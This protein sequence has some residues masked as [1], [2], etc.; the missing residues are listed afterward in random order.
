MDLKKSI[1]CYFIFFVISSNIVTG[2]VKK[3]ASVA[4]SFFKNGLVARESYIGSDQIL[5]SIKTYHLVGGL[6]EKFYFNKKKQLEGLCQKFSTEG[7]LMTSWLYQKGVLSY[8]K[9]YFKE[10]NLKN[11]EITES[12]YANIE[13]CNLLLKTNPNNFSLIYSRAV[14]QDYLSNNIVSELDF[15]FLKDL[16]ENAKVNTKE[17]ETEKIN[18]LNRKLA[19][20]Y[21]RL[22]SI[23]SRYENDYLSIEYKLKAVQAE[24]TSNIY[25]YNLGAA[26]AIQVEDYRLALYFLEEVTRTKPNHNFANWV[27][28]HIYLEMEQYQKA[29]DCVNIAFKS[30]RGLYENGYGNVEDDLRTIRGLVYHKLGKTELGIG[31]LNKALEINNKNAVANKNLGIVY[32]DL[33]ENQ[34]ACAYFQKS[35]ALG[36]EKKYYNKSLESHIKKNCTLENPILDNSVTINQNND[37][38][39]EVLASQKSTTTSEIS[40]KDLPYIAPNPAIDFVEVYNY[41]PVD[42]NFNIFDTAGKQILVGISNH[43]TIQVS[44]LPTGFY[45]LTIEKDGKTEKFKLIKK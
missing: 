42:F 5:D 32:S 40:V 30:E 10:F 14:S 24:P 15:L 4:K 8:R 43:K 25:L 35:R 17:S 23:Y 38:E 9:D 29:L 11:K 44:G 28:S 22:S 31:D 33:G 45:I 19:D 12:N 37:A 21:S 1:I 41:S 13:R 39:S 18:S 36:Y 34:K 16:L 6:N 20:I 27:L 26:F 7:K 3:E 2:Q